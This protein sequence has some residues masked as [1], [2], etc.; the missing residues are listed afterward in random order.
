MNSDRKRNRA[1]ARQLE[2]IYQVQH[3]GSRNGPSTCH[4][5]NQLVKPTP[6]ATLLVPSA[7]LRRGLPRAL[8]LWRVLVNEEVMQLLKKVQSTADFGYVAFDSINATNAFGDNALHCVCVWDDLAAAKLLV[9]NGI[10]VNQPGEFGFT[11]LKIA[12]Q[13]SSTELVNYLLANGADV[14]ALDAPEVF[15]SKA[16]SAHMAGLDRQLAMLEE[17]LAHRENEIDTSEG[18][19]DDI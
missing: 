16:N 10:N 13:F 14:E 15:D 18:K 7:S 2:F 17:K 9:E 11:P 4:Q 8:G 5:P 3:Y 12:S 6:T 19:R 1:S